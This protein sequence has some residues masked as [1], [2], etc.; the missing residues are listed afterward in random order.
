MPTGPPPTLRQIAEIAGVS[1][2]TASDALR[3][4][5]RIRD[6]TREKV[7][8]IAKRLGYQPDPLIS[9]GL[10]QMRRHPQ[11]RIQSTLAF[12]ETGPFPDQVKH[13]P[14][15]GLMMKGVQERAAQLG[16]RVEPFWLGAHA[17]K[18]GRLESILRARGIKGVIILYV[19]D[20][21][22]TSESGIAFDPE[23]FACT[24]LG[25]RLRQPELDFACADHFGNTR[26]AL[27][28]L[29]LAGCQ[30][31]G[32]VLPG[33]LDLLV[34]K[35]IS[36]A[37][38]GWSREKRGRVR[39]PPFYEVGKDPAHYRA[40]L[41]KW[42]RR[43]RPDAVYGLDSWNLTERVLEGLPGRIIWATMEY[44]PGKAEQFGTDQAHE[45]VGNAS[46][47]M[48]HV[49]LAHGRHGVPTVARGFVIEGHW[50][51]TGWKTAS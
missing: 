44:L 15:F 34:E 31:I 29:S 32:L 33:G 40:A 3:G 47:D 27:E 30:R 24:T 7:R 19:R 10:A 25:S 50:I 1:R 18:P 4:T 51:T 14:A 11:T 5:G 16:Y 37:Y 17:A 20:W 39:M 23:G 2:Q 12:V 21:T 28:E 46:V 6:E 48:V 49:Q 42:A 13:F 8:D 35:R 9:I 36:C 26:R 38:E 43:Y 45:T 22:Q 41:E